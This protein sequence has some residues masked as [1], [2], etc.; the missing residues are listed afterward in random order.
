MVVMAGRCTSGGWRND[1]RNTTEEES[2]S[3][4]GTTL[5]LFLISS[6][7]SQLCV[8]NQLRPSCNRIRVYA[9][10]NF[11]EEEEEEASDEGT[12]TFPVHVE[13]DPPSSSCPPIKSPLI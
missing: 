2:Q 13:S 6:S 10:R 7:S 8:I 4:G 9:R 3:Q 12:S 11:Q 1:S 5:L